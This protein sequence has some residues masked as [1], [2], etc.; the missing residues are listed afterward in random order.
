[1]G[2]MSLKYELLSASIL[3]ASWCISCKIQGYLW[4]NLDTLYM[5]PLFLDYFDFV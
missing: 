2:Q 1:M 4:L 3:G 5:Y